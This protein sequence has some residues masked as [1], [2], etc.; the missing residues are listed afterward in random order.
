[1]CIHIH[2]CAYLCPSLCVCVHVYICVREAVCFINE[3][4]IVRVYVLVGI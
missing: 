3:R 4:V 2:V 1:M